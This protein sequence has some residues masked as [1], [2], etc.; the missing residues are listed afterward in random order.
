[1]IQIGASTACF[2]PL[3]TERALKRVGELGFSTAEVFFNSFSELRGPLLKA[4]C[5][6]QEACKIQ[7]VSVHPFSSGTEP[8]FLF[9]AYERRFHDTLE[10]YK[11]YFDAANAL[12]AHLLV[13]HGLKPGASIEE[14]EYFERFGALVQLGRAQGS[15][16]AQEN[17][18]QFSSQSPVFLARMRKALGND[19]HMVLDL[20]QAV[21]SGLDPLELARQFAGEIVHVHVSDHLPGR[22]CLPPGEGAFRFN[23]L[24][25]LL[26]DA[27]YQ[28]SFMIELYA[29]NFT[30]D[31]QLMRAKAYL[32][33]QQG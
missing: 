2:Y 19:F 8:F 1:M 25:A 4:I 30:D 24:A 5:R 10:Y 21:R 6:E 18:V 31:K 22:D 14:P 20:K 16:V 33:K 9:S 23:A 7:V 12:G 32:E 11:R 26:E 17:V 29:G 13:M 3:E 15:M 27:G 28:G